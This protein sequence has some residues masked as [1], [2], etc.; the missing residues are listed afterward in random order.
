MAVGGTDA[1]HSNA[2][3]RQMQTRDGR[4]GKRRETRAQW[5]ARG[6]P[7]IRLTRAAERLICREGMEKVTPDA[8]ASEAGMKRGAFDLAFA[9]RTDC[10]VAVFDR[11]AEG[12]RSEMG[13]ARRSGKDWGDGVRAAVCALLKL[14]EDDV[15]RARFVLVDSLLADPPLS[16]RRSRLMGEISESLERGRPEMGMEEG[17]EEK[18]VDAEA[19]VGTVAAILHGRLE[20]CPVPSLTPLAPTLTGIVVLSYLGAEVAR[21]ELERT[22]KT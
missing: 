16:T 20:E 6:E 8:V 9:D 14:V 19:V 5:A 18:R 11:I 2:Q 22:P 13:A 4:T 7:R 1:N 12:L 21:N 17:G 3:A 10:L 15:G